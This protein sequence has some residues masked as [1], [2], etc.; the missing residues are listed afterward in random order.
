MP[1][2]IDDGASSGDVSVGEGGDAALHCAALG[3]PEPRV[4]WVREGGGEFRLAPGTALIKEVVGPT[5][6]MRGVLRDLGGAY[7]CIGTNGVPPAVSKRM[8]L[9]VTCEFSL[10]PRY[11]NQF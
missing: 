6:S 4:R 5:L 7:L 10:K 2:S 8:E 1:P 3:D 11:Y 9:H